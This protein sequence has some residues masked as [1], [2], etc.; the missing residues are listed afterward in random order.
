MIT[1][2]E[3][4]PTAPVKCGGETCTAPAD[5]AMNMC[6]VPCCVTVG[7]K[8]QCAAK[9]TAMGLTTECVL[10]AKPDTSC[11]NVEAGM[12]G[13]PLVGCCNV[14]QKKCGIVSTL[15]PGCITESMLVTLPSP[16]QDCT[17]ADEADAG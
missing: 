11:P 14:E 13:T 2:S 12:G 15:R 10:P 3:P 7:G 16:L 17:P 6:V 4:A 5:F 8:E 1:C 9:S